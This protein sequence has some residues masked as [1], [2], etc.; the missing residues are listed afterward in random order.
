MGRKR[1]IL[2]DQYPY[3][4]TVRGHNKDPFPLSIDLL[5]SHISDQLLFCSYAFKIE[6]HCFV[7]M[8]NHFHMIIRTPNSNLDTFMKYFM[9]NLSRDI[10]RESHTIN[11]KFGGRYF[12]AVINNN[13]YYSSAYKYVYRNPVEA[14]LS[15]KV[16]NY[17]YSTVLFPIGFTKCLFPIFDTRYESV[18]D[19][20]SQLAWL[21]EQ[22]SV[23]ETH[24]LSKLFL[25]SASKG[26][27][28]L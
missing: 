23:Y 24:E 27:S 17:P 1:R 5:W 28:H 7:L 13:Q 18:N 26:D 22:M 2:Q 21:N 25:R 10:E 19:I 8:T 9:R 16:E 12:S 4:V 14:G 11:Q 6:I 3:H 15:D 20:E